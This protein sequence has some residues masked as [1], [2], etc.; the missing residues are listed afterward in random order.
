[1]WLYLTRDNK[2]RKSAKH[3]IKKI[4][5]EEKLEAPPINHV[6]VCDVKM[7]IFFGFMTYVRKLVTDYFKAFGDFLAVLWKTMYRHFNELCLENLIKYGKKLT[8]KRLL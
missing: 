4:V 5:L 3:E 8:I 2:L 7:D 1:M 6:P